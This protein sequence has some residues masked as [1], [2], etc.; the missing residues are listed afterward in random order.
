MLYER[1]IA[2]LASQVSSLCFPATTETFSALHSG[3]R[4]IE[5]VVGALSH[6]A[7]DRPSRSR[8]IRLVHRQA[9]KLLLA[10]LFSAAF[11][12]IAA[13]QADAAITSSD[14]SNVTIPSSFDY[15]ATQGVEAFTAC[16]PGTTFCMAVLYN[17]SVIVG[18]DVIGQGVL[19][20]ENGTDWTPSTSLPSDEMVSALS[21]PAVNVCYTVGY[22]E[23]D[24]VFAPV[25]SETTDGGQTWTVAGPP[26]GEVP[27][28]TSTGAYQ[29][30]WTAFGLSCPTTEECFVVG[31]TY[32]RGKPTGLP[33]GGVIIETQD[34]G[35]TWSTSA[36]P[37]TPNT[38]DPLYA[39]SCESALDCVAVG[40]ADDLYPGVVF[41]TTD[42]GLTWL[43]SPDPNLNGVG[44]LL[45]V[46]CRGQVSG[47]PVCTALGQSADGTSGIITITSDD[48]GV[49]WSIGQE[50]TDV[51]SH[52]NMGGALFDLACPTTSI[53]WSTTAQWGT[54]ALVDTAN[55]GVSWQSVTQNDSAEGGT[56]IACGTA[57]FCVAVV[58]GGVWASTDGG[59]AGSGTTVPTAPLPPDSGALVTAR[60]GSTTPVGGVDHVKGAKG[61]IVDV[62]TKHPDGLVSKSKT[63]VHNDGFYSVAVPRIARGTSR[64]SFSTAGS[65]LRTLKVE[66]FTG[67]PPHL[68]GISPAIEPPSG[69][70]TVTISGRNLA[71]TTS[72]LFG[73]MP[74]TKLKQLSA[75]E[76]VVTAPVGR[77]S[78]VLVTVVTSAGGP[79]SLTGLSRY[80]YLASLPGAPAHVVAEAHSGRKAG[81]GAVALAWLP[82]SANGAPISTYDIV[83]NPA[84]PKCT[85]LTA[86]ATSTTISGLTPGRRYSFTVKA[87]SFVGTGPLSA[88][89]N[90]VVPTTVPGRVRT[91]S[92]KLVSTT[93]VRL[94]FAAP[95]ERTGL[96][97]K[98]YAV[99][100]WPACKSCRGTSGTSATLTV[101]GLSPGIEYH[102]SVMAENADGN[103]S[104]ESV[105]LRT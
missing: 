93:S 60:V 64:I 99:V 15:G 91:L 97:L 22:N 54:T 12:V 98:G 1:V 89:S 32:F 4:R 65:T 9:R 83:P 104:P 40:E 42:G 53:C 86:R 63:T 38:G 82:A 73:S 58:D 57:D 43:G 36:Q 41:S 52:A 88:A 19:S 11:V 70:R 39:I 17:T 85:G 33:F 20:T 18:L 92:G 10:L 68:T 56:S 47:L 84:C 96:P 25:F 87:V 13:P 26:P 66:G 49:T 28:N 67:A 2:R 74:G 7:R 77:R 35:Q 102:F 31:S 14:W 105:A 78:T 6:D 75:R 37:S 94:S 55:E 51:P 71:D 76:V 100:I 79:S 5:E 48:N 23:T 81:V 101:A 34:G 16:A 21:C 95:T 24:P 45:S 69:S 3:L 8:R 90:S 30:P 44:E 80:T 61:S 62:T 103:G 50:F 59:G 27:E 72:V 46:S 29:E